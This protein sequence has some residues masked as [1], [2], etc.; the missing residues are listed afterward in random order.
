M[1]ALVDQP[2]RL[3][4]VGLGAFGREHLGRLLARKDV[5]IVG[6]ADPSLAAR[7]YVAVHYPSLQ[8]ETDSGSLLTATK[9][10]GVIVATSAQSHFDITRK[11]LSL[12]IP[13]LLEKPV[14]PTA[15][16]AEQLAVMSEESGTFVLPGHV[17]RFSQDHCTV[18]DIVRSCGI[19]KLIY[20]CSR[21]YRDGDHTIRYT[22]DPV[23]TT[24]I[25]D[26]DLA[27]WL[28]QEPFRTVRS[29]RIG[30]PGFRSLTTADLE[31]VSGVHCHLRTAWIFDSG[32]LPPD[33]L[34]VVCDH[35]S[36]ELDVGVGLT[37]YAEGQAK[38]L[39]LVAS[40][41]QLVNEHSH[42]LSQIRGSRRPRAVTMTDAVRGLK[43]TD[44]ILEALRSGREVDVAG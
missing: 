33:R 8:V 6:V 3:V 2:L 44:A 11:A 30:G 1:V 17:L 28:T 16:E 29:R 20:L 21:R 37:L 18:T 24:L 26:I 31:T 38:T 43:L 40:D 39:P 32:D 14:T 25:H 34:E 27:V 13:V 42:F 23:L 5:V 15:S 36:V 19:G 7:N 4:L 22:D 41:D 12:G 9:P 10:D 35:G